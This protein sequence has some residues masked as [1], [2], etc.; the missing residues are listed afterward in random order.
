M[1]KIAV[2]SSDHCSFCKMTKKWLD[3]QNLLYKTLDVNNPD[4][5]TE[6]KKYNVPGIPLIIISDESG[7]IEQVRGFLPEKLT[8]ILL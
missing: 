4:V 5:A 3:K 2:Y 1:K 8:R 7:Q 6:F